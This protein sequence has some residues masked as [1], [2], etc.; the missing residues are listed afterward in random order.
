MS[1]SLRVICALLVVVAVLPA[2]TPL[3]GGNDTG[4]AAPVAQ[5]A[6]VQ[7]P[8]GQNTTSILLLSGETTTGY[9]RSTVDIAPVVDSTRRVI[10]VE[11]RERVVRSRLQNASTTDRRRQVLRQ[12][13]EQITEAVEALQQRERRA[14]GRYE[15][16]EISGAELVR[17]LAAVDTEARRTGELVTLLQDEVEQV[18]FLSATADQLQSLEVELATL[19]GPVRAHAERVFRGEAPPTRIHLTVSGEAVALAM[20]RGNTYVREAT[21]PAN[22]DFDSS[23]QFASESEVIDRIGELYPWAWASDTSSV[24]SYTNFENGFYRIDVDHTHGQLTSYV[25]GGTQDVFREIQYKSVDR[26]PTGPP[27]VAQENG[28]TL[29]VNQSFGGGPVEA[30]VI[31]EST[32]DPVDG[33]VYLDGTPIGRTTDGRAWFVAPAGQYELTVTTESGNVTAVAQSLQ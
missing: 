9:G 24:R 21:E 14:L 11:L 13:T 10:N 31:D 30:S 7:P 22:L 29:R 23:D 32:G 25:D 27:A 3:A 28:T 26:M 19:H 5:T 4:E 2:S 12:E 16:G 17:V 33:T 18:Q 8:S 15:R 1:R 6:Q 20:V